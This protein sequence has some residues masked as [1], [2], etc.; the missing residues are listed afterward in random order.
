MDGVEPQHGS[1]ASDGGS[2]VSATTQPRVRD[3]VVLSTC[4]PPEHAKR[5][6]AR[7]KANDR[8]VSAELRYI[9]RPILSKLDEQQSGTASAA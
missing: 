4:L 9:L 6:K 2:R 3:D 1:H 8:T 7:A 5:L